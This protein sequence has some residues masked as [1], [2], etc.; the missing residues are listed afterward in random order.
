MVIATGCATTGMTSKRGAQ[1]PRFLTVVSFFVSHCKIGRQSQ[2]RLLN[3]GGLSLTLMLRL[4][5]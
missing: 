1:A 2:G 4:G 3:F 5:E